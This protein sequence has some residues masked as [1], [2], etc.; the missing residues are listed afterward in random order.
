MET[1]PLRNVPWAP[2]RHGDV[3]VSV[4]APAIVKL[5]E[6]SQELTAFIS[7]SKFSAIGLIL[8]GG[9]NLLTGVVFARWLKPEMFGMYS[10]ALVVMTFL[11]GIGTLGADNTIGRFLA[12]YEGTGEQYRGRALFRWALVRA[13]SAGMVLGLIALCLLRISWINLGRLATLRSAASYIV[14]GIPVLTI[15]LVCFQGL[16]GLQHVRMRIVIDKLLQPI[17]RLALPLFLG[18]LTLTPLSAALTGALLAAAFVT[19]AALTVI[20]RSLA[21]ASAHDVAKDEKRKWLSYSLPFIL[22]SVQL[23][24]SVGMGIDILLVGAL[25]SVEQSGIYA[26]AFRFTP[27]LVLAR[28]AMDFAFGPRVGL[29]YG[30]S[31]LKGIEALYK[32]SSSLGLL[33]SLPLAVVLALFSSALLTS[34]FGASYAAGAGALSVLV[35]GLLADSATGCNG[36]L[37]SMIGRPWLVLMNGIAGGV[38]TVCLCFLLIPKYGLLGAAVAVTVSRS[39]VNVLATYEIWRIQALQPFSMRTAKIL[40][41][42]IPGLCAGIVGKS[43]FS[44][45]LRDIMA[46]FLSIVLVLVSYFVAVRCLGIEVKPAQVGPA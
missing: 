24:V 3:L 27:L 10:L 2:G 19:F 17:L 20:R 36:T 38:L 43:L 31:D 42:A 5:E 45:G 34:F 9:V 1:V 6:Q 16:L 33:Y 41:S 28:M 35:L 18:V 14:I 22:Y 12:L 21:P 4:A 30:R 29:L 13:G 23:F 39:L 15:Q 40:A 7:G 46:L 37:L 11:S 26:A 32:A 25:A 8:G 44:A